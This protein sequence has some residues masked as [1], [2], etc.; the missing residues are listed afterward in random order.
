M[1]VNRLYG[2]ESE[3]QQRTQDAERLSHRVP[4]SNSTAHWA[5]HQ[6]LPQFSGDLGQKI[7]NI[8]DFQD[9][10]AGE[11]LASHL[12]RNHPDGWSVYAETIGTLI[13]RKDLRE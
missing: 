10:P 1:G 12:R 8:A 13:I 5:I 9:G 7:H 6:S 11:S 4:L 2:P 3:D